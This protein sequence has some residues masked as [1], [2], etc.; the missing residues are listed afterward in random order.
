MHIDFAPSS[1][2]TYNNAGSSRQLANYME[3]EDLKRME[4]G[5]YTNLGSHVLI[6]YENKSGQVEVVVWLLGLLAYRVV[7]AHKKPNVCSD[8]FL[9]T[10]LRTDSSRREL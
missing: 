1:N 2:G 4:K 9:F 10:E 7:L 3:H 5:V 8:N 6:G